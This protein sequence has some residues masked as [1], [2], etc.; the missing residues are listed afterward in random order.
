MRTRYVL[1]LALAQKQDFTGAGAALREYL[2]TA[3][4]GKE[5]EVIR[6]Q[7]AQIEE[8]GRQQT[9]AVKPQ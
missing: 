1:G 9:A 3:K 7:L 4:E 5:T 8:A 6:Q 2:A